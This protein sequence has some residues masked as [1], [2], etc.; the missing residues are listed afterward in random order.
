M[1][2]VQSFH[3][4]DTGQHLATH[5]AE[6]TVNLILDKYTNL[7]SILYTD[8]KNAGSTKTISEEKKI[9]TNFPRHTSTT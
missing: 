6:L 8:E 2:E 9:C 1:I 7:C 3:I 4:P 5:L